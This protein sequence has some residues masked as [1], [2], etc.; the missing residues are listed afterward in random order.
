MRVNAPESN[1]LIL[2][3]LWKNLH[4]SSSREKGEIY[5][6]SNGRKSLVS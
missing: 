3:T 5:C 6:G 2:C 4:D 1:R